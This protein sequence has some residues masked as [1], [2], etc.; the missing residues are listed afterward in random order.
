MKGKKKTIVRRE[1]ARGF[2]LVEVL[3]S[4]G[5]ALVILAAAIGVFKS[6]AD[7]GVA[8]SEVY[9]RN[10]EIQAA[11]NLI[12][13]DLGRIDRSKDLLKDNMSFKAVPGKWYTSKDTE[14]TTE[15]TGFKVLD[16]VTPGVVNGADAMII[17]Y[18][19]TEDAS[20]T[21]DA[22]I[23]WYLKESSEQ[24]NGTTW[25]MRKE[26]DKPSAYVIPGVKGFELSYDILDDAG[27]DKGLVELLAINRTA[28]KRDGFLKS[29][30][31]IVSY[32]D[33]DQ[34][35]KI[36]RVNVNIQSASDE[37]VK[38]IE[39]AQTARMAIR[40]IPTA[41][42]PLVCEDGYE[43][44]EN[45]ECVRVPI[46]PVCSAGTTAFPTRAINVKYDLAKI[47]NVYVCNILFYA[48]GACS[49]QKVILNIDDNKIDDSWEYDYSINPE[50]TNV[51]SLEK[52]PDC[53]QFSVTFSA[54]STYIPLTISLKPTSYSDTN[55]PCK[56][57]KNGLT[58][59]LMLP[60]S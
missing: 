48:T 55:D 23:T 27:D 18:L 50:N 25:L 30:Q 3:I 51:T 39:I 10:T 41:A 58:N 5:I 34:I 29:P 36:R 40:H 45:G 28:P 15:Y 9:E 60:T 7:S 17:S 53:N 35:G 47:G 46:A 22:H 1:S 54:I 57:I 32:N 12:R 43:L 11:L 26:D 8:A 16:Y 52:N 37:P 21:K 14:T 4:L 44:D 31:H 59:G 13:R 2:S 38:T 33:S 6:L 49:N 56:G 42:S 24:S 20:E 19:K